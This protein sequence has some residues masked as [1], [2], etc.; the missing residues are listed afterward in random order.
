LEEL[1]RIWNIR[2]KR[3]CISVRMFGSCKHALVDEALGLYF[4]ALRTS[5]SFEREPS[6]YA[7]DETILKSPSDT[8][9]TPSIAMRFIY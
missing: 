9:V 1:G 2:S 8:F 7:R 5:D 3:G 4:G 6:S